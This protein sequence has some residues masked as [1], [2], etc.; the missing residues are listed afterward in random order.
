MPKDFGQAVVV[1]AVPQVPAV[2]QV[3]VAQQVQVA[4]QVL[5]RQVEEQQVQVRERELEV[6]QPVP[7]PVVQELK[8]PLFELVERAVPEE[9]GL[10]QIVGHVNQESGSD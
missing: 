9:M 8:E 7:L 6:A 1:L 3:R 4:Q 5:V 2:Q 10:N